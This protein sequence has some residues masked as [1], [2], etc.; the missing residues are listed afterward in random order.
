MGTP[1]PALAVMRT[2]GGRVGEPEGVAQANGVKRAAHVDSLVEQEDGYRRDVGGQGGIGT[3]QL[4]S[5][6]GRF[7]ATIVQRSAYRPVVSSKVGVPPAYSVP[8]GL[9]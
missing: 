6:S 9:P 4:C 8:W 2:V 3:A 1:T 5:A 7:L